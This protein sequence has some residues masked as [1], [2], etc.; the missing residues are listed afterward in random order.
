MVNTTFLT[1]SFFSTII[2]IL[3]LTRIAIKLKNN[4]LLGIKILFLFFLSHLISNIT[5]IL[6][7]AYDVTLIPLD[8]NY[9][10]LIFLNALFFDLTYVLGY[11]FAQ[12]IKKSELVFSQNKTQLVILFTSVIGFVLIDILFVVNEAEFIYLFIET[13]LELIF[14]ILI[15]WKLFMVSIKMKKSQN[16]RKSFLVFLGF[17]FVQVLATIFFLFVDPSTNDPFNVV[18]YV[19]HIVLIIVGMLLIEGSYLI[20]F[21]SQKKED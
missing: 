19:M 15:V 12:V 4:N 8:T 20:K 1:F 6:F 3:L 21:E 9:S 18:F 16:K 17:L 7:I 10:I 14:G 13:I 11:A 2:N 5:T